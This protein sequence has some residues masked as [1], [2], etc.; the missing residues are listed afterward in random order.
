MPIYEMIC[1]CGKTKDYLSERFL[2]IK[3][4]EDIICECGK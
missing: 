1:E 2:S 3:D 4:T